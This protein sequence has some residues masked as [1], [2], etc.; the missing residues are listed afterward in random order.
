MTKPL[1]R[2]VDPPLTH[3][4]I[5]EL[6][7]IYRDRMD[8]G[9]FTRAH[10]LRK[11]LESRGVTF[12]LTRHLIFWEDKNHKKKNKEELNVLKRYL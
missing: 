5:K 1:V 4:D 3:E 2:T 10:K 6:L 11:F 8:M 9:D 12:K 7:Y